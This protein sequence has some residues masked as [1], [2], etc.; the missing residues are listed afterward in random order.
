M[1][2]YLINLTYLANAIAGVLIYAYVFYL[3]NL[4]YLANLVFAKQTLD[5]SVLL[6]KFN[7]PSKLLCITFVDIISVL[8]NKF[9]IPSK[10]IH[11]K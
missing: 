9:N 10:H 8:L 5:G 1:V 3:I 6:N 2:F 11:E 7:I 4:T